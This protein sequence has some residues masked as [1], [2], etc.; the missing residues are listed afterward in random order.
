MPRTHISALNP[1]G[2][3]VESL[4]VD[5]DGNLKVTST[6]GGGGAAMATTA[7]PTKVSVTT[8]STQIIASAA[9][10]RPVLVYVLSGGPVFVNDAT[11]TVDD[12]PIPTGGQLVWANTGALNG[13]VASGTAD[14]RVLSEG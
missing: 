2:T 14:V 9:R 13:I 8:A 12:F 11:A 1:G 6:G 7:T 3:P 10:T 5:A 4:K